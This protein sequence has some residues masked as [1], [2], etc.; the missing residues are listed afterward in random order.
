[1][2]AALVEQRAS[3]GPVDVRRGGG[4]QIVG[5]LTSNA[6]LWEKTALLITWDENGGFFDHVT[7]PTPPAGTPGEYVTAATLPRVREGIRGPIGLGFRVPTLVVSPFARGGFVCSDRFDHTSILRSLEARFGAEVP[8]LTKWRRD[9]VGDL[10]SAFNFAR[11]DTSVPEMPKPATTDPRVL[12]S[13]CTSEPV[14]LIPTFGAQL[15]GYPVPPNSMP[16]QEAG[17]AKRPSG[18]CDKPV[19][20]AAKP[21]VAIHGLPRTHCGEHGLRV[22][23]VVTAPAKLRSVRVKVNGRSVYVGAKRRSSSACRATAC[24]RGRT[25][26]S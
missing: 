23:I 12:A 11:V 26:S 2:L 25:A 21:R 13:N 4:R 17:D 22:R 20:A 16:V 1:M 15:P 9:A 18:P 5:A 8:N 19:A 14:T 24:M 6:E 7:P 3:A 10:T